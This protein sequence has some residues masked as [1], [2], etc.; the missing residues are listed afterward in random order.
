MTVQL[1][2]L[3]VALAAVIFF[4]KNFNACVYFVVMVDIFLRIITYLKLNI[5][6]DDAFS[7]MGLIPGDIPSLIKSFDIGIF[8]EILMAVYVVIYI[9]FEVLIVSIFIRKKY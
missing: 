8:N 9:I 6:R 7:F 5:L 4:C 3:L 1:I 2:I